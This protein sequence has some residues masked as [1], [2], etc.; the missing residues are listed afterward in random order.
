MSMIS[1]RKARGGGSRAR[2]AAPAKGARATSRARRTAVRALPVAAAAGMVALAVP[3]AAPAAVSHA[4]PATAVPD[5]SRPILI[6]KQIPAPLTTTQ[7]QAEIGINCYT[8]VQYR[9]AYDL[10]PLY[11]QGHHRRGQDDRDRRL[12]RLAD[13]RATTSRSSTSS[14]ASPTPT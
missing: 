7:C 14:S 5:I 11:A 10:N 8:P 1:G 3:A 6:G 4:R 12:L 9:T 13:H 2:A